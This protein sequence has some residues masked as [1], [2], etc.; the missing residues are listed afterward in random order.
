MG[1]GWTYGFNLDPSDWNSVDEDNDDV[2]RPVAK[3][4]G[5]DVISS[6]VITKDLGNGLTISL[7]DTGD[8][9]KLKNYAGHWEGATHSDPDTSGGL[10][11]AYAKGNLDA[12]AVLG[13]GRAKGD[14]DAGLGSDISVGAGMKFGKFDVGASYHMVTWSDAAYKY[15]INNFAGNYQKDSSALALGAG[16]SFGNYNVGVDMLSKTKNTCAAAP[17]SSGTC[18][19]AGETETKT[20]AI[21]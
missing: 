14:D 10:K 19:A 12:S 16:G 6:V 21:G 7:G 5:S 9:D 3:N 4:A 18:A 8:G 15:G 13:S 17:M 11:I 2:L 1:N 20:T